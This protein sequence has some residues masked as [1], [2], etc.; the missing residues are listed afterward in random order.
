MLEV[1]A[2][3]D[4]LVNYS[5]QQQLCIAQ[6]KNSYSQ[7]STSPAG[8]G[9][10]SQ[11]P[12]KY[13][14]RAHPGPVLIILRW[15]ASLPIT[16]AFLVQQ[17]QKHFPL[18]IW[19]QGQKQPRNSTGAFFFSPCQEQIAARVI[20]KV[21]QSLCELQKRNGTAKPWLFQSCCKTLCQIIY[22]LYLHSLQLVLQD[23]KCLLI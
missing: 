22:W 20:D 9:K 21:S 13:R 14:G 1:S 11:T 5:S 6:Q 10:R 17:A 15:A 7:E 4:F 8:Q 3:A 16:S 12:P 23:F 2:T 19:P 18:K